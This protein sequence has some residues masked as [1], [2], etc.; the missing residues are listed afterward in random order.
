MIRQNVNQRENQGYQHKESLLQLKLDIKI[1]IFLITLKLF[2]LIFS[3]IRLIM[4]LKIRSF[5]SKLIF[6]DAGT[7]KNFFRLLIIVATAWKTQKYGY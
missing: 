3:K 1:K 6:V 5:F 7:D 4:T 2:K